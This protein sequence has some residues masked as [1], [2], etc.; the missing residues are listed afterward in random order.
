[1]NQPLAAQ[2]IL[3]LPDEEA[4][5]R[6][7]YDQLQTA[8]SI[9]LIATWFWDIGNDLVYGDRNLFQFFGVTETQEQAGLPLNT[10][11][12][13]IHP[14]DRSRTIELI[15]EA[16]Q[17][18]T[19]YEA[20]YR[21]DGEGLKS[22]WVLARGQATYNE[23]QLPLSLSGVLIDVTDRKR[24]EIRS[25][26]TETSLRLAVESARIGTWD[27]HPLTG[28]LIWSDRCKELFGLP[29]T[30]EINYTVFLQGLHPD[31][32]QQT[33][34][35]VQ[36]VLQPDS[37]G[38][39]ICE[40][41]TIGFNNGQLRW[42][43]SNGQTFTNKQGAIERFLGTVVDI[44]ADKENE[45][46][47]QQ[48]VHQQTQALE[49]QAHQLRTTLDASL[50]SIIAMTAIRNETGTIVDFMMDT[51]N[52]AVIRSNFMTPDQII[53][54]R[55]LAVFPGN[56]DNGFFDLYIRVVE[57]GASEQSTQYYRDEF[58]LEGW[59]EVSAVKQDNDSV[60]VTF[61]NIT[62]RKKAELSAQQQSAE[63]KQAN[64]ELKRSNESLQQFA[65]IA[66]HDLQEPLR[67]IQAFSD[68]L[69]AQFADNLSDGETDMIRRIQRSAQRMQM[70]VKDLLLYS[71]LSTQRE[72][73]TTVALTTVVDDVIS[74]L[75]MSISEKSAT[76]D[77][78]ALPTVSGSS[79]RLRQLFQNLLVNA[80][81]F[82]PP[83]VAPVIQIRSRMVQHDELP[84][85]LQELHLYP[86]WLIT[87]TDNGIGF[88]ERYK[89]RIF[90]PFQRLHDKTTYS[91]TGI[92]L[93]I[94]QRVAESHGGMMDVTSQP[95]EGSTF[96]VFLPVL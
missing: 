91:G 47:L 29:S 50:N 71:K 16:L 32:R 95:G 78:G 36:D 81:K 58:G 46:L 48:R 30:A 67:R 77:V 51:A 69:K 43:R 63:L 18:G 3:L 6:R 79:S 2:P 60:V 15:N 38:F 4:L 84:T 64:A 85:R 96:K 34:Q 94:C 17:S 62:E 21:I 5:L 7:S 13:N 83:N 9:G 37:N 25:Q 90:T 44:T 70:L 42:I 11:T 82:S 19:T 8:L 49:I 40:Y 39:F 33:D 35:A 89:D 52:E 26:V 74:D 24:A 92:G 22:R 88:D 57:I 55:L 56:K 23:Q 87:V 65:H 27:F 1:M 68:L 28:E 14:D 45:V 76:I 80:L 10:F 20:E 53:G 41:R 72:P 12:N 75:E 61:N 54:R 31:D 59:F 73:F 86:F 93:A 66:S